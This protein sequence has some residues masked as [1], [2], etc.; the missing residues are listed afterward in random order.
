MNSVCFYIGEITLKVV[1]IE[2]VDNANKLEILLEIG[3]KDANFWKG[4]DFSNMV[5][6]S[7]MTGFE[8]YNVRTNADGTVSIIANYN[9][10]IHNMNITVQLDPSLSGKDAL[11][12]YPPVSK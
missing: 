11:S 3:P 7:N 5:S 12:R 6:L 8:N 9:T 1:Y 2:K 10:T 4:V